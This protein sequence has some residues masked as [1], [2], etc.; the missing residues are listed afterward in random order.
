MNNSDLENMKKD[1]GGV[2]VS[3][4]NEDDAVLEQLG[5]RRELRREFSK[6]ST[7]SF[8]FGIMGYGGHDTKNQHN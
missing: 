2:S 5:I 7:I 1:S 4:Y 6:F 8:S 3:V